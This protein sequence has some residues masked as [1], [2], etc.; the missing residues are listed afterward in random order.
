MDPPAARTR[1]LRPEF[2]LV[3]EA[4]RGGARGGQAARATHA[5]GARRRGCVRCRNSVATSSRPRCSRKTR[6]LG[7]GGGGE[8]RRRPRGT[9]ETAAILRRLTATAERS[10][11]PTADAAAAPAAL[12]PGLADFCSR[13]AEERRK[14][15]TPAA[16]RRRQCVRSSG[17]GGAPTTRVWM[18]EPRRR[19]RRRQR[20]VACQIQRR[21]CL[22]CRRA[23]T[24][25]IARPQRRRR[26]RQPAHPDA[27]AWEEE[28][29]F[30][31]AGS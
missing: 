11:S 16:Q 26:R 21:R 29:R 13:A 9:T 7:A 24:A 17:G 3:F 27:G 25:Y 20:G 14:T 23:R 4:A 8:P 18:A 15:R 19:M 30:V 1:A 31:G 2:A 22:M 28:D 12:K 5:A 6:R 10:P